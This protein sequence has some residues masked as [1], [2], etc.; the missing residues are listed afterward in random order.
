MK[1]KFKLWLLL[2]ALFAS[3]FYF[4]DKALAQ[5]NDPILIQISDTEIGTEAFEQ[6]IQYGN[7]GHTAMGTLL[8]EGQGMQTN[9]GI[10]FSIG[11][12]GNGYRPSII[13]AV[14]TDQPFDTTA[15]LATIKAHLNVPTNPVTTNGDCAIACDGTYQETTTTIAVSQ[16]D[17]IVQSAPDPEPQPTSQP[18]SVSVV[19]ETTTTTT[20]PVEEMYSYQYTLEPTLLF[21]A[22]VQQAIVKPV[23]KIAT[24][25]VINNRSKRATIKTAKKSSSK[26]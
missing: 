12:G 8:G 5:N 14:W 4:S 25:K 16:P 20:I 6:L 18:E 17:P 1:N 23:Q 3:S 15:A 26:R 7:G 2:P 13:I 22:P 9:P 21:T 19:V 10:G 11:S 24:K